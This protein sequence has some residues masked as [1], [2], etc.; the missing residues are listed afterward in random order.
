MRIEE[1]YS[2][3]N[4]DIIATESY[5]ERRKNLVPDLE[6]FEKTKKSES[7]GLPTDRSG[8]KKQK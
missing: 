2:S 1:K 3:T 5:V 8:T 7:V 4:P 6:H